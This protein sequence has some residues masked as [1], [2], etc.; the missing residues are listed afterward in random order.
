[1][2]KSFIMIISIVVGIVC[3]CSCTKVSEKNF[4]G[5]WRMIS[6]QVNDND[7]Y[8]WYEMLADDGNRTVTFMENGTY[9]DNYDGEISSGTWAYIS[10]SEQL[11]LFGILWDVYSYEKKEMELRGGENGTSY[12][13]F[14][15]KI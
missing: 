11:R 4:V 13:V 12:R 9:I 1:M 8:G 15:K 5:T 3:L 6:L 2:K 7:G 14:L 10:S